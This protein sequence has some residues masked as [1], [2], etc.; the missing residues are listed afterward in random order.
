MVHLTT[1]RICARGYS[2]DSEYRLSKYV[3]VDLVAAASDSTTTAL[4]CRFQPHAFQSF[5]R[6]RAL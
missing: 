5:Y 4:T 1:M 2:N 3:A 6:R